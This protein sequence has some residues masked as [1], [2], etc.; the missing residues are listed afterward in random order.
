MEL[1]GTLVGTGP[2]T[3]DAGAVFERIEL[4]PDSWVDVARSWLLG[5]D[6]LFD[7]LVRDIP[8]RQGRR[9]MWGRMVDDPRLTW[10]PDRT[11]APAGAPEPIDVGFIR[12]PIAAR[13]RRHLGRPGYNL[14]RN[15]SDSVAFHGDRELR[16]LQDTLVAIVTLGVTRPFLI[17]ADG[18]GR[19]ID[20]R[21]A[22]GDLI[23]MGG[24]AQRDFE[25]G[26]PK[27]RTAG[28][29]ISVTFRTRTRATAEHR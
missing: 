8:W 28:P 19:S 12:D 7:Q 23:V 13:Y 29:R 18:G 25:H 27:T 1:Q 15:G 24:A 3:I 2:P 22:A 5:A 26:V 14:Y 6:T 20:L 21:P 9:L 4:G 10:W 11:R 17:R 16:D